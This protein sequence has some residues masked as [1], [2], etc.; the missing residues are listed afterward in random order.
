[1]KSEKLKDGKNIKYIK[2]FKIMFRFKDQNKSVMNV[3]RD[4]ERKM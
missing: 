2:N 4:N 3:K 1:M